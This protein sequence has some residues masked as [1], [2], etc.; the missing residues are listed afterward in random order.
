[1]KKFGN[2][3]DIDKP[4]AGNIIKDD[5]LTRKNVKITVINMPKEQ[6]IEPHPEEY[7][8]LFFIIKGSAIFTTGDGAHKVL[9]NEAIY[10]D[11]NE[12]RGIKPLEDLTFI[13]IKILN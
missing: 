13:G 5:I 9:K 3:S 4:F 2:L 1:M 6:E 8:I 12:V 11:F 7:A 10:L